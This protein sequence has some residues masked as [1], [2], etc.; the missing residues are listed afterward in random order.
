[1]RFYDHTCIFILTINKK[2]ISFWKHILY[3][4]E[5]KTYFMYELFHA[6][7]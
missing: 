5:A 6:S 2:M 7:F 3:V 4:L 1:M